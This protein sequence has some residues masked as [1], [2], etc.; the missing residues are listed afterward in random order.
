MVHHLSIQRCGVNFCM[1]LGVRLPK[2]TGGAYLA[3]P[4]SKQRILQNVT[5]HSKPINWDGQL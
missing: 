3:I 4:L 2:D 1:Q 5:D